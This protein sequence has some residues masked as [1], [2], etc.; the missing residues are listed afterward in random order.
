MRSDRPAGW[1]EYMQMLPKSRLDDLLRLLTAE[2]YEIVGPRVEAGSIVLNPIH[3]SQDL[4]IGWTD[5]Q[6]PGSYRLEHRDRTSYFHFVVGP[7]SWKKYLFTPHQKL[8]SARQDSAGLQITPE[9]PQPARRA[10]F[11]VRA[12]ELHAIAGQDHVF[13]NG[14]GD[15][16]DVYYEAA[17][18]NVFLIAV[19]CTRSGENCFCTSAGTG[20]AVRPDRIPVQSSL[21]PGN[22]IP[23][24][25]QEAAPPSFCDLILTELEHDFVIRSASEAGE[26]ILNQLHLADAGHDQMRD[27]EQRVAATAASMNRTPN[28][29]NT[30]ELLLRN[31]ESP[32]WDDVARRCLSCANCTMVCP[33]CFCSSTQDSSDLQGESAARERHWDSCFN[34]NFAAVH[35]GNYR[36]T[37]RN[38]YRH[39][40]TH[41][42]SFWHDQFGESGC[43]GCGRCIT[44]C[45]VGIDVTAEIDAIRRD[46]ARAG[47]GTP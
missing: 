25:L 42:F 35:G 23:L 12:C 19:E 20:P 9:V 6:G 37:I 14:S 4:P 33:T 21:P 22:R 29:Q 30:R 41:K 5:H 16:K 26:R 36:S 10:F 28:L 40:L 7:Q 44:W 31:L 38:R 11:G 1:E 43:V 27:A 45:P 39:W 34:P 2:G 32:V 8:W 18:H 15:A 47:G 46:D 3:S 24:P 17:R 13:L